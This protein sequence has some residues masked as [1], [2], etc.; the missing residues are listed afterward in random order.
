MNSLSAFKIGTVVSMARSFVVNRP[1]GMRVGDTV[2]Y[3]G[4][5]V[6]MMEDFGHVV[7]FNRNSVGEVVIV[8]DWSSGDRTLVHP[9]K[10]T[11]VE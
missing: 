7:A 2:H 11:V 8:V 4:G 5:L 1:E 10:L 6:P 9:F 3:K